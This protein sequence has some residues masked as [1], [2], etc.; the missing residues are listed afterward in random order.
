VKLARG[1]KA[2]LRQ[3]KY[4]A[5]PCAAPECTAIAEYQC[6]HVNGLG[7]LCGRALCERHAKI[8]P[9]RTANDGTALCHYCPTHDTVAKALGERKRPQ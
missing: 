8:Q 2:R 1:D 5:P 4:A 7:V 3:R 6:D 9:G